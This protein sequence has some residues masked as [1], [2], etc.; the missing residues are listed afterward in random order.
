MP[1]LALVIDQCGAWKLVVYSHKYYLSVT[2]ILM[3]LLSKIGIKIT[4]WRIILKTQ[5]YMAINFTVKHQT[6]IR[7]WYHQSYCWHQ[8]NVYIFKNKIQS[9]YLYTWKYNCIFSQDN[10]IFKND[11]QNSFFPSFK[12]KSHRSP[13]IQKHSHQFEGFQIAIW[14]YKILF[15]ILSQ[16]F[17]CKNI[18][19]AV[20]VIQDPPAPRFP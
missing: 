11:F 5:F 8:N 3:L 18:T 13:N 16:K 15:C 1:C 2:L 7:I 6:Q 17:S 4:F 19:Q 14:S 9:L 10:S 20:L 12:R